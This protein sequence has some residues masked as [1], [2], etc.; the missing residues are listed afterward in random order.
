MKFISKDHEP[1]VSSWILEG[2]E[3]S[4]MQKVCD[5]EI[6]FKEKEILV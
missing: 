1:V 6:Y 2:S 5:F 3:P 4:K